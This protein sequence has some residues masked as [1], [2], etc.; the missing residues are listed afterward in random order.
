MLP[1]PPLSNN[2]SISPRVRNM[3]EFT[4]L[5]NH[6][7]EKG[8]IKLILA[9]E[10]RVKYYA[11][12]VKPPLTEK[13]KEREAA[14]VEFICQRDVTNIGLTKKPPTKIMKSKTLNKRQLEIENR[15]LKPYRES[16]YLT[17]QL[18]EK[19]RILQVERDKLNPKKISNNNS[20][21]GNDNNNESLEDGDEFNESDIKLH[22]INNR[23]M[24]ARERR[25]TL[26]SISDAMKLEKY[27]Q[28][29]EESE[30]RLQRLQHIRA[31]DNKPTASSAWKAIFL[32]LLIVNRMR[33][34]VNLRKVGE[35]SVAAQ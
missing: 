6:T 27:Q 23:V 25:S 7:T 5:W 16:E 31:K 3:D 34:Y 26:M 8:G 28:N 30:K 11:P 35:H 13:E 9:D 22:D 10:H 29:L 14:R 19:V 21:N 32:T 1:H 18:Y 15:L 20:N 24:L 2:S 33:T 17:N 4:N 12:Y